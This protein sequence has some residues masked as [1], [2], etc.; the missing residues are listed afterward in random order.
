[1]PFGALTSFN[2]VSPLTASVPIHGVIKGYTLDS[3]QE[4]EQLI[5]IIDLRW[6]SENATVKIKT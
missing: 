4:N 5:K 6:K 3:V 2:C 1:M